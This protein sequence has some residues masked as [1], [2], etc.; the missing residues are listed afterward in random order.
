MEISPKE[1][2]D[3]KAFEEGLQSM[4]EMDEVQTSK[5]F[6]QLFGTRYLVESSSYL[7]HKCF[8]LQ[9]Q[10][11]GISITSLRTKDNTQ[12]FYEWANI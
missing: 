8:I 1:F 4:T 11:S 7:R 2:E 5:G 3:S 9:L 12:V 6:S 10:E